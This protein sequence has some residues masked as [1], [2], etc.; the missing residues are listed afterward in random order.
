MSVE[1]KWE[2]K[3]LCRVFTD[4]INGDEVLGD[5]LKLQGDI[6]FDNIKYVIND[7]TEV[8]DFDFSDLDV[9]K[10]S[11]NDNVASQSNPYLKIAL[12]STHEPLLVWLR[13]YCESMEGS[14]YKSKIFDNADDAYEWVSE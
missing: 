6:R 2:S 4:T 9:T 14:L 7:F 13:L 11:V 10:I 1:Y 5:N 3:G 12:I 8:V